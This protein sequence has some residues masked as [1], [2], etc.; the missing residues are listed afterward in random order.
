MLFLMVPN[1]LVKRELL[2][3]VFRCLSDAKLLQMPCFDRVQL[4]DGLEIELV[5]GPG[6]KHHTSNDEENFFDTAEVT[7]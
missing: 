4:L 7:E 1:S 2:L 3:G 6:A 5:L